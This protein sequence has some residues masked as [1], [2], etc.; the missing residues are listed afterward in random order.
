MT[1]E[2][3]NTT[4]KQKITDRRRALKVKNVPLYKQLCGELKVHKKNTKTHL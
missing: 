4:R 2:I 3:V 1:H